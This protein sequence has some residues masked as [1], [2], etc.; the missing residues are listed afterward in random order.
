MEKPLETA[1]V[2][3][4][5]GCGGASGNHQR[6]ANNVSQ[7]L[8]RE[9]SSKEQ[10][11]LPTLLSGRKLFLALALMP[12]SSVSPHRFLVPVE[13]LLQHWNSQRMS[14]SKF[15]GG[16]FKR[17]CLGFQNPP[18]PSASILAGFTAR[19]YGEFY[20]WHENTGLGGTLF[21]KEDLCS[22]D[23]LIFIC[24]MQ[25]WD[26]PVPCFQFWCGFLFNF[27]VVGLPF[28]QIL[29]GSE[30]QLFCSLAVILMWLW[31]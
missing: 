18:S 17:N 15:M 6:G 26:Q 21:L 9:G 10:W 31:D 16:P 5:V 4:K 2:G 28:S 3:L 24:Y 22:W 14:L 11:S 1:W 19:I 23:L 7:A 25:V 27:L 30:C 12:G 20:S 13:L 29:S 8:W